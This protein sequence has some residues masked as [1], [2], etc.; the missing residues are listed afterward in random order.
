MKTELDKLKNHEIF[1]S[2]DPEIFKHYAMIH[3]KCDKYN[4]IMS[5]KLQE[6]EECLRDIINIGVGSLIL[7]PFSCNVG[8]NIT[9]GNN[10][11]INTG[12]TFLDEGAV[13]I[14]KNVFIGPNLNVYT[15]TH[16]LDFKTRN[17][18]LELAKPTTIQ[19]N[20]W[21]GGNVI[22]LP[23]VT[24]GE[25][26]VIG[27]GSIVSKDIPPNTLN[28][29]SPCKTIREIDQNIIDKDYIV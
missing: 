19:D 16:P 27:A 2:F 10:T 25:G 28:Y 29:G 11:F 5:E 15:A 20:V 21:I 3:T 9:V 14:G 17:T 12:S 24:I 8:F 6:K 22:I 26:S 13:S 23:G 1:N 4:A 18:W 7:S